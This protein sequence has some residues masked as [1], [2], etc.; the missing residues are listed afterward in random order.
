M[1]DGIPFGR[2]GWIVPDGDRQAMSIAQ[3]LLDAILPDA[4]TGA[5]PTATIC[6]NQEFGGT[7]IAVLSFLLPPPLDGIDRKGRRFR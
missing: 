2:S 5:V 7:R 6:E 4:G 1:F 3:L